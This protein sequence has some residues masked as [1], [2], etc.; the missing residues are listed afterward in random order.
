M[1]LSLAQLI[2][3]FLTSNVNVLSAHYCR[4]ADEVTFV[5]QLTFTIQKSFILSTIIR[6]ML[7]IPM[8]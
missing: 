7:D 6:Q 3:N 8:K 5:S 1:S 2:N 4:Y